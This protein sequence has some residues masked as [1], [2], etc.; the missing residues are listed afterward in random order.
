MQ[1]H[2]IVYKYQNPDL[3]NGYVD[4]VAIFRHDPPTVKD[5][6]DLANEI[7]EEFGNKWVQILNI[8]PVSEEE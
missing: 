5:I 8:I 3:T 2:Y 6:R 4:F 7:K 1:K